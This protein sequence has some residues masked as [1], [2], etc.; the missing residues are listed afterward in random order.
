MPLCHPH[1][2]PIFLLLSPTIRCTS[3]PQQPPAH[4]VPLAAAAPVVQDR[5]FTVVWNMP[6][7]DC[8]EKYNIHLDLGDFD[9]V[10]NR[11]QSFQGQNMSIFY[12]DHLGRYPY[13]SMETDWVNGGLPQ[14]G[15]LGGHLSR[16]ED[17][18]SELLL[19]DFTGLSVVDWEEWHPL[20]ERNFGVKIKYRS[21]SKSLV[22]QQTPGLP[23]EKVE[24]VARQEF[25]W[26]AK[27]FM[28]DTLRL[29]LRVRPRGLWGF[30]GFPACFNLP[31]RQTV[32]NYTGHCHPRNTK[33]NNQLA[34]LWQQSTA[35]YP[36]IYLIRKLAGSKNAALMVRH[37]LLEAF[38]VAS[39]WQ[40]ANTDHATPVLPYARLAFTHTLQFLDKTDLEHT[41]GESAAL[42]AS[43]VVLWGE[44]KF[45]KSKRQ[46]VLLRG[47]VH[48]VLGGY[49]RALKA[50]VH[51]CS[52]EHCHGHGR[53]ARKD[54]NSSHLLSSTHLNLQANVDYVPRGDLCPLYKHF[55]CQCY[56]NWTGDKCQ[57]QIEA[58]AHTN[59]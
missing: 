26:A 30:Y 16:A 29:G 41:L 48:S 6:T 24:A 2:L 4:E 44:L 3:L 8:Q 22:R 12:R 18:I 39:R 53:C 27:E 13:L 36:S 17:Q 57:E 43:G 31:R 34:W 46:C 5:P 1:L 35:L 45:A 51:R 10:A 58:L 9:I 11:F 15:D 40:Y 20:W 37:R 42:G 32:G 50:D 52:L 28:S 7:A 54:P 25:E 38:R 55:L 21:L 23:E 47:Y 19:P 56:Q 14:C 59:E 33:Q 49:I